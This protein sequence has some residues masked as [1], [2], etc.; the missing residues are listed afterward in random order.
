VAPLVVA[1]VAS[2]ES[3]R[4]HGASKLHAVRDGWRVLRVIIAEYR[5]PAARSARKGLK[6]SS[7]RTMRPAARI[8]PPAARSNPLLG[9]HHRKPVRADAAA[10]SLISR[11]GDKS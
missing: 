9:R 4:L 6:G 10:G 2:F 8:V 3:D 7:H 1:E 5:S 11:T